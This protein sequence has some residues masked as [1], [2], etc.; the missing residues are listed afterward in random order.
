[1]SNRILIGFI[2]TITAAWVVVAYPTYRLGGAN[3]LLCSAVSVVLCLL[4]T[5]VTLAWGLRASNPSPSEQ[6]LQVV[7]GTGLR[8]LVALGGGLLF[9]SLLPALQQPGFW[10]W[11]LCFYLFTLA[12]EM[13]L[14]RLATARAAPSKSRQGE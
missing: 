12:L 4:P 9:Y 13:V 3:M 14:L 6:L 2:A 7:S 11:L 10:L 5:T 8:L 1:M